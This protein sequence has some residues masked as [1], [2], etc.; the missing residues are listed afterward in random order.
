MKWR[1]FGPLL[2]QIDLLLFMW[3][4][5]GRV[6]MVSPCNFEA[7]YSTESEISGLAHLM[8]RV[9]VVDSTLTP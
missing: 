8:K 1:S 6:P 2:C 5:S 3:R 4:E 9:N 7:I